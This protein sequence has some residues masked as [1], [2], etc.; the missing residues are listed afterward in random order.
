MSSC[1]MSLYYNK[2]GVVDVPRKESYQVTYKTSL[3]AEIVAKVSYTDES[4]QIQKVDH[5]TG[6]WEKT[7][8]LKAGKQVKIKIV[9]TG[10]NK[11]PTDYKVLVDGKVISEHTLNGKK[12]KFYFSFYLP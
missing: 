6:D 9:A 10:A 1:N 11:S 7:V 12:S 2:D 4:D 3:R 5:V 8:T